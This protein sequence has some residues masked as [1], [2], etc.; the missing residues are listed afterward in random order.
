MKIKC[1]FVRKPQTYLNAFAPE[2]KLYIAVPL[3]DES[4]EKMSSYGLYADGTTRIPMPRKTATV[5]NADGRWR[6]RRDL[7]KEI[8]HFERAYHIVDWHGEDHYGTCWQR[9]LCYQR[10]LIPPTEIAFK[11][12]DD[13]LYSPLFVNCDADMDYI[14]SAINVLLEIFGFCEIWTESKAP[15]VPPIKQQEVPW[16]ILR[17][18]SR[19]R[20]NWEEY[21]DRITRIRPDKQRVVI[22][23]RHE[24]LWKMNPDFCV[25]GMENFW[26]YVVYGFS[27]S[28]IYVFEC[29]QPNNATYIFRGDW[30]TA[31]KLT[32]TEILAGHIQEARLFHTEAW[33]ENVRATISH[34]NKEV[35]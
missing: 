27:A 23:Q 5:S 12:E 17:K 2:D 15:A 19:E 25:L 21:V 35:A 9:R 24:H 14:K 31:S 10:E 16:E 29:N 26:G 22:K 13:V 30:E 3:S 20:E 18:G 1:K 34:H 11:V 8:R 6:I 32:K 4:I 28:N 33:Y 7:P